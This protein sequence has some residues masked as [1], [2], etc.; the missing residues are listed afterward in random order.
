MLK[1]LISRS[2]VTAFGDY[3]PCWYDYAYIQSSEFSVYSLKSHTSWT[4]IRLP[5]D[6]WDS[7]SHL[8]HWNRWLSDMMWPVGKPDTTAAAVRG[9]ET[10][11]NISN[12]FKQLSL[13]SNESRAQYICLWMTNSG[14]S[15]ETD[16]YCITVLI[17]SIQVSKACL[18]KTFSVSLFTES[19]D[20]EEL[21][22]F[23][24]IRALLSLI[25]TTIILL[26]Y[27]PQ[28]HHH[29]VHICVIFSQERW[30]TLIPKC[31]RDMH[32]K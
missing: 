26:Q 21:C 17:I 2:L 25:H 18:H 1:L 12:F 16:G 14:N 32:V 4:F 31:I 24:L 3:I 30:W 10:L 11:K 29:S 27:W 7:I 9:Q 19:L 8:R 6:I 15:W 22:N 5:E 13:I 23:F 28:R 20:L